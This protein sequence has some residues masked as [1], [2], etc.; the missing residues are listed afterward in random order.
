MVTVRPRCG[1]TTVNK[2]LGHIFH[3]TLRRLAL[4][5]PHSNHY[6]LTVLEPGEVPPVPD[7]SGALQSMPSSPVFL[8][9]L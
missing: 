1:H 9:S 5:I 2:A 8:S 6:I 4:E 7:F 3:R